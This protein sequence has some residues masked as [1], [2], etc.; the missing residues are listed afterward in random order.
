[1]VRD[2]Y[3]C[4]SFEPRDPTHIKYHKTRPPD[5]ILTARSIT[6]LRQFWASATEGAWKKLYF[7]CILR[8]DR[9]RGS[10]GHTKVVRIT[11]RLERQFFIWCMLHLTREIVCNTTGSPSSQVSVLLHLSL[12]DSRNI[13]ICVEKRFYSET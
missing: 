12:R 10:E 2:V 1:M 7:F 4:A 3:D 5:N 11:N 9:I 8:N 6:E 13:R